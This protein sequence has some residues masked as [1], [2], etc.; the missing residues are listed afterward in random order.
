[1]RLESEKGKEEGA[2]KVATEGTSLINTKG[3]STAWYY[4]CIKD[5]GYGNASSLDI[6]KTNLGELTV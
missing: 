2:A 1:M 6:F 5:H 3:I 4:H